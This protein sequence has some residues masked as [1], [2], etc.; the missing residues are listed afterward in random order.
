[1]EDLNINDNNFS[2][3]KKKDFEEIQEKTEF[4]V[5]NSLF[6]LLFTDIEIKEH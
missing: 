6:H 3:I 5:F 2:N 4:N 1:M